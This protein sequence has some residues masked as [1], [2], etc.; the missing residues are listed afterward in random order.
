MT[1]AVTDF[2]QYAGLRAGAAAN[3]PAV[4][5]EVAG[6]FEALF[7][8]TILKNMRAGQLAEPLFGSDQ[9]EM[10]LEM[11]DQQLAAEMARG[12]GLGFADMLVRQLGGE[13]GAATAVAGGTILTRTPSPR[14]A[15]PAPDWSTPAAFVR[16]LWP[17]ANRVA[18]ELRVAPEAV[19]AQA[20]LETGWGRHVVPRSDGSSSHNLF[21]IKAGGDWFGGSVVKKT[22]EF[23]DG[24]A[25]EVRARFRA[26]PDVA[27]TFS[28]YARFVGTNPRY[29][30]VL[31]TADDTDGFARALQDAGY[32]TD[33][34][35]AAKLR[36]ILASDVLHDA[37]R[38]LKNGAPQPIAVEGARND[39]VR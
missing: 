6:Q 9:H 10:Y 28:D 29:A 23:R 34:L 39:A 24:T 19:L 32:A 5:R 2:S 12:R 1:T 38:P 21:G 31:G 33:P 14:P 17:H 18:R 11:R 20:A 3:D 15:S 16:D 26:Y 35:Y 22:I 13:T 27:A 8:Q 4:L 30:D 36:R 7:M 25:E 37:V